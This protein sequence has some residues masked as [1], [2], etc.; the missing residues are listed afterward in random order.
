M[1]MQSS[2]VQQPQGNPTGKGGSM[3]MPN[4]SP[5]QSLMQP[6]DIGSAINSATSQ[7]PSIGQA[8]PYPN[9]ISQWDNMVMQQPKPAG[10]AK[11]A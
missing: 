5:G 10:K 6:N 1:G 8:N 4:S 3:P 11:G 9:T 2:Q 7:Q